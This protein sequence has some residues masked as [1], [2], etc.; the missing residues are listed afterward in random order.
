MD[1]SSSIELSGV[2]GT[3]FQAMLNLLGPLSGWQL[4]LDFSSPVTN[5]ESPMAEVTGVG[6]SWTLNN[7]GFDGNVE[8]GSSMELRFKVSLNPS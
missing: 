8:E 2:T 6:Q 7:L 1:C 5:I 3:S 4:A